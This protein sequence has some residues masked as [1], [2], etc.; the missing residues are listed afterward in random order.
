MRNFRTNLKDKTIFI[1]LSLMMMM[2]TV[3]WVN[4]VAN[5]DLKNAFSEILKKISQF[6]SRSKLFFF[7]EGS[8]SQPVVD[9]AKLLFDKQKDANSQ[10]LVENLPFNFTNIFF[11][12]T[13]HKI[14]AQNCKVFAKLCLPFAQLSA[15][16]SF[17]SCSYEKVGKNVHRYMTNL[18]GVHKIFICLG[19]S[20]I[21]Q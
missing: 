3:K 1:G 14:M 12:L 13:G 20:L 18:T 16:K 10:Y 9:F 7:F 15:E 17:S 4:A 8:G 5:N 2:M 6:F 11:L 19:F 21:K